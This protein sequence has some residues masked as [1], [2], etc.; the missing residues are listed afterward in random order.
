MKK[1]IITL[2][3][4]IVV[5]VAAILLL[6]MRNDKKPKEKVVEQAKQVDNIDKYGYTLFD[7]KSKLYHEKFKELKEVL[8]EKE[9][10]DKKYAKIV[11][12]MFAA[13]FYDLNTK[14]SNTDI[15]GLEFVHPDAITDFSKTATDSMYKY[16]ET[17][18]YGNRKQELPSVKSTTA[19]V[20]DHRYNSEKAKDEK[21]LEATIDITYEKDLG[22]PTKVTVDMVHV[23]KKLYI[24]EVK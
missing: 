12:E 5:V 3:G 14:V 4:I 2:A 13:D 20:T 9:I 11:A 24:V 6:N 23:D 8:N 21:G 10:D 18:V 7:N 17:N 22:Y 16:V 15:G 19:T 1:V